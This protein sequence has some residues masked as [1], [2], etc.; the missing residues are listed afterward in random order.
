MG[1]NIPQDGRRTHPGVADRPRIAHPSHRAVVRSAAVTRC[2]YAPAL[3]LALAALTGCGA[4]LD[5]ADDPADAMVPTLDVPSDRGP[6]VVAARDI[7]LDR[8]ADI[9][10]AL[11]VPLDLGVDAGRVEMDAAAMPDVRLVDAGAVDAGLPPVDAPPPR[12][13]GVAPADAVPGAGVA[14]DGAQTLSVAANTDVLLRFDAAPTEHVALRL[15]FTPTAAGVVL[16]V[17]RWD[18]A[19]P[20]ELWR[21]DGGTG[22]RVLAVF[23][24]RGRRS[25]WARVRSPTALGT[26]RLTVTRTPFADGATCPGDC[27]RLMQLPVRIDRAED[28]YDHTPSTVMRY[29]FGRRDLV[30]F[31]RWAGRQM[32]A[33][34]R[35]YFVPEDF[36]QWDGDIP[37]R[38]RGAL[39]H[40]SHQRGK[41]V[42][43]SL[44]GTD[45]LAPWRSYCT[46]R[47]DGSGRECVPGT[48]RGYDGVANA[49]FFAPFFATGRVTM[50]FLDRELL[51]ATRTSLDRAVSLGLVPPSTRSYYTNGVGIQHWPNHDNHIHLRVSES[52]PGALVYEPFAPP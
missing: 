30:M 6:D 33:Q 29:Q 44:Y 42:D 3:L 13:T 21:T 40:A 7:P 37:G 36:S 39:R 2:T 45:G 14:R 5:P 17:D 52:A 47:N 28:G 25:F 20:V 16:S 27:A 9:V 51:A 46:T 4:E 22:L 24:P 34:G 8:G 10:H 41:D 38:D 15:D 35:S 26:A 19:R 48:V 12:P 1:E 49:A 18:G 11:D 50:S 32:A 31:V 43:L 23:D